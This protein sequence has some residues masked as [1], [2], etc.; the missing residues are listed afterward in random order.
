MLILQSNK[1]LELE[2]FS[3]DFFLSHTYFTETGGSIMMVKYTDT[4]FRQT[5]S[6]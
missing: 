2:S 3:I 6:Q 1:S 4:V 5:F